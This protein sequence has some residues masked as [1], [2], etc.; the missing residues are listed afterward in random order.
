ML[1]ELFE[2]AQ[3][4][5]QTMPHFNPRQRIAQQAVALDHTATLQA[6]FD[7]SISAMTALARALYTTDSAGYPHHTD[8][9]TGRILVPVPWGNA[10]WRAWGLR[11]WEAQ[12][13]N[14]VLRLMQRKGNV[15]FAYDQESRSWVVDME[16]F[17]TLEM[18]VLWIKDRGP[19]FSQW[20]AVVERHQANETARMRAR[21]H[22]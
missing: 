5:S 8:H 16:L 1:N 2:R 4:I 3:N 14:Q 21:R 12:C 10:G 6:R 11:K 7:V 20:R 9:V 15:L 19:S 18:A 13:L 22:G 17:P